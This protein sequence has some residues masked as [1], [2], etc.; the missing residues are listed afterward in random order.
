MVP[1]RLMI[2]HL[3]L[4]VVQI[5]LE[6]ADSISKSILISVFFFFS[7]CTG[8]FARQRK[9]LYNLAVSEPAPI[10]N[11]QREAYMSTLSI[12]PSKFTLSSNSMVLKTTSFNPYNYSTTSSKQR[13]PFQ[14]HEAIL[15][16]TGTVTDKAAGCNVGMV[17]QRE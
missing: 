14:A 3:V 12:V 5:S 2:P 4:K 7:Q 10:K 1:M 16:C 17:A 8:T 6:Y 13:Q 15:D 9:L 11:A